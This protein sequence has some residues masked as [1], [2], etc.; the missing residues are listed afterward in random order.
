MRTFTSSPLQGKNAI[1]TGGTRG[2]GFSIASQLAASGVHVTLCG[3][4]EESVDRAVSALQ[5]QPGK[6]SGAPCDV[7]DAESIRK[8]YAFVDDNLGSLDI[9]VNN[10]GIGVFRS[11]GDLQADEWHETLRTNLDS[12]YYFCHQAIPR[13]KQAGG[14][15]IVNISSLAGSNAFAGG[16]AYNASKFGLNGFSEALMLDHR[17]DRIRVTTICPGSVAT[18]FSPGGSGSDWKIQ[19]GD[20]A[21]VVLAVLTVPDRTLVSY[22]E[23]RPSRPRKA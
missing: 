10:A 21:E 6:V 12:V 13:F 16:S 1:V 7:R 9:L 8:F 23:M 20:V 18:E 2:I 17:Y 3:R 14:G 15:F 11:V 5:N 22:V 4:S 19:P